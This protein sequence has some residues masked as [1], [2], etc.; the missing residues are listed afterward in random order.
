MNTPTN[1]TALEDP[2]PAENLGRWVN[3]EGTTPQAQL[4][5]TWPLPEQTVTHHREHAVGYLK[6]VLEYAGPK[7]LRQRLRDLDLIEDLGVDADTG[8]TGTVLFFSVDLRPKGQ[9]SPETVLDLLYFYLAEIR[10]AGVDEDLY[11]SLQSLMQLHFSWKEKEDPGEVADLYAERLTRLPWQ[12]LLTG[13]N[14][15]QK[16]D[17]ELVRSLLLLL[18]PSRMNVAFVNPAAAFRRD[19]KQQQKKVRQDGTKSAQEGAHSTSDV[20]VLPHYGVNY[21][22]QTMDHVD[23]KQWKA[24]LMNGVE[25][26]E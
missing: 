23:L 25:E 4:L 12:D 3:I 10:N 1:W 22:V 24:W 13:D 26:D 18:E 11:K 14:L 20:Q 15:I 5:V 17:P 8:Y 16:V 9:A 19:L 2:W 7:G 6:Y 21:T